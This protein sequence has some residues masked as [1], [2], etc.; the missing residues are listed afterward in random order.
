MIPFAFQSS[1]P[2]RLQA[3]AIVGSLALLFFIIILI[4]KG[5]L[6][7]GYSIVWF[8]VT[9]SMVVLSIFEGFLDYLAKIVGITYV[10]AMLF[11]IMV[12]GLF[13]LSIHFSLLFSRYDK[14]I[15]ALAQEYA[16]LKTSLTKKPQEKEQI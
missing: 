13:L 1:V 11:L 3:V 4:K 10:P 15:R 5:R 2:P 8:I 6:K 12:L 7:E 9:L 14:K 16:M